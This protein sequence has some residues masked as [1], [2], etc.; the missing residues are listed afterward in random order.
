MQK[1][2]FGLLLFL[3]L[4]TTAHALG[5]QCGGVF[6]HFT[7][8]D[9]MLTHMGTYETKIT[10]ALASPENLSA[11]GILSQRLAELQLLINEALNT[12]PTHRQKIID[13]SVRL[14]EIT[15]GV[16]R[17][18]QYSTERVPTPLPVAEGLTYQTA[19]TKSAEKDLS[20]LQ[21]YL[22]EKYNEFIR[23]VESV[24]TISHL[25]HHWKLEKMNQQ[26]IF[27]VPTY[28]IRINHGYR[29]F[30]QLGQAH[31]VNIIAISKTLSHGGH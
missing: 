9:P 15:R 6:S 14:E 29:V 12:N 11:H 13:I 21:P 23:D 20:H 24:D 2:L 22:H 10:E 16:D 3:T 28:S 19:L 4:G 26:E 7:H 8:L 25:P 17:Q 31:T 18:L 1:T 30:F 27:M 5:P